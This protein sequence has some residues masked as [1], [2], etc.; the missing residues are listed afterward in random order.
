MRAGEAAQGRCTLAR[1]DR[2]HVKGVN[3]TCGH[4]AGD[5]V[6]ARVASI[7]MAS[8]R[9]SDVVGRWGGEEFILVMPA[10]PLDRLGELLEQIREQVAVETIEYDDPRIRVTVSIGAADA[11]GGMK[12]QDAMR[13]ADDRLYVAKRRGR[14][15]V[16][17]S[18]DEPT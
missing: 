13:I 15:R 18:D 6:P 4:A 8:I 7:R 16:V 5:G 10:T 14:N 17:T 3:D 11:R 12:Y 9:A 1:V 2:A